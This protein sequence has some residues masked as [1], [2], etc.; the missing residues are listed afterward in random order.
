[1]S[2][3]GIF[4]YTKLDSTTCGLGTGNTNINGNGFVNKTETKGDVNVPSYLVGYRVVSI[5]TYATRSCHLI[6]KFVLP[7]TITTLELAAFTWMEGLKEVVF[8]ASITTIKSNNDFYTNAE[9]IYFEKGTK[10]TTIGAYFIR[11]SHAVKEIVIPSSVQSIGSNFAEYCSN[12]MYISFCGSK[13]FS[14]ISNAFLGCT[15]FLYALIT[16][17]YKG[18]LFGGKRVV[19]KLSNNCLPLKDRCYTHKYVNSWSMTSC[20]YFVAIHLLCK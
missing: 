12:L 18:N 10:V 17:D 9:K 16:N 2:V 14:V 4:V 8:P 7:N 15:N 3:S 5:L 20:Y 19:V 11:Y 1:M 13:D 6:T